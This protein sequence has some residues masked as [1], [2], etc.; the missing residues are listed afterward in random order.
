MHKQH[1]DPDPSANI[2]AWGH[3]STSV[4]N[5]W[6]RNRTGSRGYPRLAAVLGASVKC[7]A[8]STSMEGVPV[9]ANEVRRILA[10][11]RPLSVSS[12]DASLISGYRDAMSFVL[13]RADDQAFRWDAELIRTIHDFVLVVC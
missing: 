1:A 5:M 12:T 13:R 6:A 10:G 3:A 2:P 11:D 9:T 4:A 8:A 7:V